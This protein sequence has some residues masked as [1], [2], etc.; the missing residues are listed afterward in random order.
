MSAGKLEKNS[1]VFASQSIS[2][3]LLNND[4]TT[5]E[6]VEKVFVIKEPTSKAIKSTK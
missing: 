6:C 4:L 2:W 1:M 3:V 5:Y